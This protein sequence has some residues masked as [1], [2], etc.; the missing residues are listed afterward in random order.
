MA[1]AHNTTTDVRIPDPHFPRFFM[2]VCLPQTS[3]LQLQ[4]WFTCEM[5]ASFQTRDLPTALCER[6]SA[7]AGCHDT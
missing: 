1:A 2:T 7:Q 4:P 6:T 5:C 3:L